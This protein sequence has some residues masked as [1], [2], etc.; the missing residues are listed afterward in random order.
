LLTTPGFKWLCDLNKCNGS[1]KLIGVGFK[2]CL[3]CDSL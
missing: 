1:T 2:P 3:G